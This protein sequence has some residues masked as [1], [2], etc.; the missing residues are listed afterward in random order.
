V[1]F[2][3]AKLHDANFH[4]ADFPQ[5]MMKELQTGGAKVPHVIAPEV[6]EQIVNDHQLWIDTDG[7]RGRRAIL[8][9]WYLSRAHLVQAN[10]NGA[11]LRKANLSNANLHGARLICS[12]LREANLMYTNLTDAD[13]RGAQTEGSRGLPVVLPSSKN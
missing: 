4:L 13:L 10:L 11:D 8:S 5:E 6:L 3:N 2:K 7:Q 9:G 12:D 1:Q